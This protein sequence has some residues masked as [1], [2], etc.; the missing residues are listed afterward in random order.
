MQ[1]A[2]CAIAAV[3][4]PSSHWL[5]SVQGSPAAS[6]IAAAFSAASMPPASQT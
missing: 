5:P 6:P 2:T 1:T 4:M 3:P